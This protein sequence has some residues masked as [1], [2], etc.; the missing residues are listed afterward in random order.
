MHVQW[1][2]DNTASYSVALRGGTSTLTRVQFDALVL[3][4]SWQRVGD[5]GIIAV[6][7][8]HLPD[9]RMRRARTAGKMTAS[10][11]SSVMALRSAIPS[12]CPPPR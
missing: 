4:L 6:L 3:G 8:G 7:Q 10:R 9:L 2:S 12:R 11:R 5:G 1:L